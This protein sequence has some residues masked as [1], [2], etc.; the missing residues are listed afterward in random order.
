VNGPRTDV[1]DTTTYNYYDANTT[2]TPS[3]ALPIV[4]P[5]TGTSPAN[6]GCRGQLQSMTNALGKTTQ[7]NRYNHHGQVEQLT[8]ANGVVTTNTY[9]LRQRL[10]NH[11]VGNEITSLAYD[12]VGQVIQ[13]T[14]P[15]AST[16]NYTYDA[17][18]RLTQIQDTVG[19]KVT[20][21]LDAAGNR[22]NEATTD[23]L[24]NLAKTLT[25][26]YDALNRLQ[27]VTGV[28]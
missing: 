13:L 23:P 8:D 14:M 18:H 26:S 24:G 16:L 27:Q 6:L 2:C 21:T 12:N 9:D 15:D 25:R 28:Q 19:N 10:L 22:T 5:I 20:Y 11:K 17:A 7:F 4:D 1:T 3:A